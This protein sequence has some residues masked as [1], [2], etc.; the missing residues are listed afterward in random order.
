MAPEAAIEAGAVALFGEK[1][2][3][4][5]RV[6][7]LGQGLEAEA[8][9]YSV[10]LC[11]GTHVR[12]T[13]DIAVF[14]ITSEGAVAAGIRR[15]EAVTGEAARQY[16]ERQAE[17]AR[18]SAELLKIKIEDV[19]ARI[20]TLLSERKSLEKELADARKQLALGGGAGGGAAPEDINGVTFMGRVLSG[21]SGKDLRAMINEHVQSIGSGIV[22]FVATDAAKVTVVVGVTPDLTSTHS[23]VTLVNAGASSY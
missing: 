11:G 20:K 6:L 19:P 18:S 9:D 16:L 13:G 10:E 5:V 22:A 2:G 17:L 15:I 21:V 3:D 14:K 7:S 1:Y 8:G 12:R 4:E 23:A